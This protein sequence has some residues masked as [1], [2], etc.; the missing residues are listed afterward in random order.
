MVVISLRDSGGSGE[1]SGR[2]KENI[3]AL[4]TMVN[5][6]PDCGKRVLIHNGFDR[7]AQNRLL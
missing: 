3:I 7:A 6:E 5:V 1:E 2:V 4:S